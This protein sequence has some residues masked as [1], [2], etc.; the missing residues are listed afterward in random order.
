MGLWMTPEIATYTY[1]LR[2]TEAER[3]AV[4]HRYNT[5]LKTGFAAFETIPWW[6]VIDINGVR[7]FA[8]CF[9]I[10]GMVV[11]LWKDRSLATRAVAEHVLA[12][13]ANTNLKAFFT[14]DDC[15]ANPEWATSVTVPS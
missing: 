15:G 5:L 9:R 7:V 12:L 2:F 4:M 1:R 3:Q 11:L 10:H 14:Y 13:C 6:A 8:N